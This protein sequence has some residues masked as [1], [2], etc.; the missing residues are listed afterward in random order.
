MVE[1]QVMMRVGEFTHFKQSVS[2]WS[3]FT[4]PL[5]NRGYSNSVTVYNPDQFL[6]SSHPNNIVTLS[7]LMYN[8]ERNACLELQTWFK[9]YG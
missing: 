5:I 9:A 6:E 8:I 3:L 4:K 2:I 1:S 7:F